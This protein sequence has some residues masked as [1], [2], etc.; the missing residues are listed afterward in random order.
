MFTTFTLDSLKISNTRSLHNDTDFV[1]M[2]ITV[3]ANPP[4]L[5]SKSLGDLNNGTH[6][7][8]LSLEANIPNDD[9]PIVF[10]YVIANNG[11]GHNDVLKRATQTALTSIG[12]EVVKHG[13]ATAAAVTIG[14]VL[15]PLVG[16]ALTALAG[17][18]AVT[19]V[20]SLLFAD[21]DGVVAAG[22][23]AFTSSQLI[24][25]TNSGQKISETA[26][27]SGTNSPDGCGSNS[28][29]STTCTIATAPSIA[30]VLDLNGEWA[31]GGVAGPFISVT[32]NS[33][34]IDMSA[35]HRPKASGSVV[36]STHISVNFPD[37]KTYTAVLQAPNVIKWS[38]NSS[39]TKVPAIAT[40]IDL[41]GQWMSGGVLGPAITVHGNSISI[42]MSALKR[43]TAL[44]K[45]VDSS[46]ISVNFPDDKTYTAVL[47]KPG[48]IQWSNNSSWTKFARSGIKHLFVLMLEN[49]SFDHLLGFSGIR[50]T[51]AQTGVATTAEGLTGAE[52]NVY[53][54]QTFPVTKSATDRMQSGPDHQ[55]NDVLIQLC[56]PTFDNKELNGS[57]YPTVNATG[58]A[59]A[60]GIT[61]SK[62]Q[63]GQA[64]ACFTKNELPII[65]ALA[66]EFVVCDHWFSSMAGPTEPNRMFVH[67]ATSGVWDDSPTSW[68]Q[69][70]GELG[71]TD[72]SFPAGTIYDRLRA[73]KIPFRIYAGDVFPNVAL[74][75]G[76]SVLNDIDDF[77]NF[78]ADINSE[79][80]DAAY[81][82]I[83][84]NYDALVNNFLDGNSQHPL[85]SVRAGE[86]LIKQVYENLRQ[87]PRWNDSMLIVTWDE[88]GGFYDHVWPPRATPTGFR[89]QTHWYMFDQL[90]PR[91][92]AL[93]IS[94]WCRKNLIEHR[95]LEHSAVPA[96]IEQLFGLKP[97]T[98][99][100]AGLTGLQAL[101]T[102]AS[103][104]QDAPLT[105]PPVAAASE[106]VAA[107]P[108]LATPLDAVKNDWPFW[109]LRI[110]VKHHLE[111]SPSERAA[112]LAQVKAM[113]TL[114][115]LDRYTQQVAVIMKTRQQ[116]SRKRRLAAQAVRQAV[117]KAPIAAG[118]LPAP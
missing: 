16:S 92:P 69:T 81:T 93:V 115:D 31:S 49:R 91:V 38:N 88:H 42:D 47:Q 118:R 22:A 4:V 23:L 113:K 116:E 117:P 71:G 48:T 104:R 1:Y 82:F 97:L 18:L 60:Y 59:A 96:T 79:N 28:R 76:I 77:S 99:R 78:Q 5:G 102:L 53:E 84:P 6:T 24:K 73:A 26:N 98:V 7:V 33:I 54:S 100:D 14:A 43:P 94:P 27:H 50:G 13:A 105:L 15:V 11:H 67:A 32:G 17:I 45:I 83:E 95:P 63:A 66:S 51:D 61:H 8:A 3:G 57:P 70:Q 114:N 39:W 64:M 110:A 58:Y 9:T 62:A 29:Y 55:F 107:A 34:S 106:K 44:G 19:E 56:G 108:N 30:T 75:H 74:L 65:N 112:I 68:Q 36:D 21:C 25:R 12:Q 85:A 37:D 86:Q 109:L 89:G 101:A 41:N 10:G 111:S 80:F 20:A 90:G 35:S 2:S 40:V 72:I 87:S 52:S 46:H 103:P